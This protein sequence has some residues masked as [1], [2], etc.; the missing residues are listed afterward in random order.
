MANT[1]F[2][3]LNEQREYIYDNLRG[4]ESVRTALARKNFEL[5][6]YAVE[7]STYTESIARLLNALPIDPR[8]ERTAQ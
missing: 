8:C 1:I 3:I 7:L 5:E 2:C 6:R 4:I